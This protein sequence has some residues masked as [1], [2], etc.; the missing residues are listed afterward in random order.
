MSYV[1]SVVYARADKTVIAAIYRAAKERNVSTKVMIA[2]F[3]T[4]IVESEVRNVHFGDRDSLGVFQQR[5]GW[6][7]VATRL[8]PYKSANLF[9]DEALR[10]ENRYRTTGTLAQGVQRSAFPFRYQMAYAA[11]TYLISKV[12]A[13]KPVLK[14]GSKG[15]EVKTVQR[16]V[17]A[18]VDGDF[19]P[20]TEAKVKFFQKTHGLPVDGIV[21]PKTWVVIL[22]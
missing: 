17:G 7:S 4:A 2:M 9:L 16:K 20:L 5:A 21:G 8:D 3:E 14:V 6:G 11:A 12:R 22:K 15:E 18:T 19:G 10:V 1:P 13:D